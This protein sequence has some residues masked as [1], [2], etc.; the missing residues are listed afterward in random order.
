VTWWGNTKE[1]EKRL[2]LGDTCESQKRRH[3]SKGSVDRQLV[4]RGL[5]P[6]YIREDI[7]FGDLT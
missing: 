4:M 7:T 5:L 2:K 3:I 6:R 1:R